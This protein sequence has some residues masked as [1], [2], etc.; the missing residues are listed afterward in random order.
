MESL[1]HELRYNPN[2]AGLVNELTGRVGMSQQDQVKQMMTKNFDKETS[3]VY[4]KQNVEV[5]NAEVRARVD[6]SSSTHK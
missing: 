2:K 3:T 6:A 4:V 1:R 5:T